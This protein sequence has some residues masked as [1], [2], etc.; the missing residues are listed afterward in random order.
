MSRASLS[1]SAPT[2]P[3]SVRWAIYTRKSTEEGLEQEFNSLDAQREAG[4]AYIRS[5]AGEGWLCL[6]DRFD[7]GGFT[8]GN[9]DRPALTRLLAAIEAGQIDGVVVYKVDRLSRSLLDFARMMAIFERAKVSFVSVTQQFNTATS[10]GRLVLNVLLSFAQFEREIISERTRDKIAATRRKGKWTGGRPV[11]GYDVTPAHKL[12]VNPDEAERV[13][14]IFELYLEHG[15][16]LPVVHDLDRRGWRTKSWTTRHGSIVGGKH[17]TRTSLYQL[18]TNVVFLGKVR[19]KTETHPGEHE[20]IVDAAIWQRVQAQ[21]ARNGRTGGREVRN[22]FGALLK[23]LLRCR[24]C[25]RAMSPSQTSKNKGK[26]RYRYYICSGAQKR[27]WATCPTKSVPAAVIEEAVLGQ[28]KRIGEDPE[29]RRQTLAEAQRQD[30]QQMLA[31][32]SERQTQQRELRGWY[33]ELKTRAG[34]I[35]PGDDAGLARLADLQER[36]RQTEE[37]LRERPTRS[38]TTIDPVAAEQALASFGPV[39]STLNPREQFR[40]IHLLI[41]SVDYDGPNQKIAIHFRPHGLLATAA[42]APAPSPGVSP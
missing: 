32:A 37:R 13:R 18:L 23:G 16:L 34:Q 9:M 41:G 2:T 35:R 27:G 4:E 7:D 3:K 33:E 31:A 20:A 28:L 22:R 8:G 19:Y 36:I 21:L 26:T 10:M 29:L 39:W 25:A 42:D 14:T 15:S 11:L 5:Q 12:A 1:P 38:P 30:A 17:F 24:S 40:L 6:P